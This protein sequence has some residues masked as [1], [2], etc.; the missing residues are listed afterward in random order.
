MVTTQE[1]QQLSGVFHTMDTP[2]LLQFAQQ[3][4]LPIHASAVFRFDHKQKTASPLSKGQ[5]EHAIC[6]AIVESSS[7]VRATWNWFYILALPWFMIMTLLTIVENLEEYQTYGQLQSL[8]LKLKFQLFNKA[9]LKD[10]FPKEPTT[11]PD[12]SP[13]APSTTPDLYA[14]A[15]SYVLRCVEA[16]QQRYDRYKSDEKG[17][18][19]LHGHPSVRIDWEAGP[20]RGGPNRENGIDRVFQDMMDGMIDEQRV[21][22]KTDTTAR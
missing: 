4:R 8:I 3:L 17:S 20:S 5:I 16:F 19:K 10:T 13:T 18:E 11:S 7:K 2:A 9:F 15:K 14:S 12:S 6:M 21:R 1:L 22:F